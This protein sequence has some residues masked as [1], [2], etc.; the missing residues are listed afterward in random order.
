MP[1]VRVKNGWKAYAKSN[2]VYKKKADAERQ[3]K[4]I[5]ASKAKARK[6]KK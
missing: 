1:I 2:T 3:H 5:Q 4:A 6:S